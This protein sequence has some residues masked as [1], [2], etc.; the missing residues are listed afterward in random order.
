MYKAVGCVLYIIIWPGRSIFFIPIHKVTSEQRGCVIRF[1]R[2]WWWWWW[3]WRSWLLIVM[4]THFFLFC[5]TLSSSPTS[6]MRGKM[7]A[8]FHSF[9][10]WCSLVRRCK[11]FILAVQINCFIFFLF[12]ERSKLDYP[13]KIPKRTKKKRLLITLFFSVAFKEMVPFPM[14]ILHANAR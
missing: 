10:L 12:C 4:M 11:T 7:H 2:L 13:N 1:Y 14:I 6:L 8:H 3:W 5:Y 9:S